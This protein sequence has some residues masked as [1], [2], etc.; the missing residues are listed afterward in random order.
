MQAPLAKLGQVPVLRYPHYGH[1]LKLSQG[2]LATLEG[3]HST[4]GERTMAAESAGMRARLPS[5][6]ASSARVH[7]PAAHS[8]A[9]GCLQIS[10]HTR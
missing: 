5:T 3:L 4:W 9:Q 1:S 7:L 8:Q 6:A 2:A 10:M